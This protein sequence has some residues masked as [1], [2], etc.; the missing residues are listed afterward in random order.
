MRPPQDVVINAIP[1]RGKLKM[2]NELAINAAINQLEDA[3]LSLDHI[4]VKRILQ[5]NI[6][7][8]DSEHRIE[9]LIVP[10]LEG[11]G[12]KWEQGKVALSQVYL[13]G[14]ICEEQVD[15]L[16]PQGIS[17]QL[18]EAQ[19]RLAIA[20]LEDYH[21]LGKRIVYS[22]LRASGFALRDYGRV[23]VEEL[24]NRVQTDKIEILLISTLMLPSALRVRE[25][26]TQLREAGQNVLIVVGGAPFRFDE[27]LWQ[28][29]GA[30]AMGYNA[31]DVIAIFNQL[32]EKIR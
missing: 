27:Q 21:L 6:D 3:L 2:N 8:Q 5:E 20:V 10:A 22:I 26:R 23:T 15:R 4:E 9:M 19:P 17:S 29:V 14:R 18:S 25:V 13:S 1:L 7:S 12:L 31:S 11:I 16:F 24:V 30:D 28:E 32:K